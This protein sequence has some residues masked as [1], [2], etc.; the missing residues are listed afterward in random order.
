MEQSD[1]DLVRQVPSYHLQVVMKTRLIAFEPA[2]AGIE[3][4]LTDASSTSLEEIARQIF[5]P[6]SLQT[7]LARLDEL[8]RR[9]LR[10]LVMCGGRANSRDLALYFTSAG[11]LPAK[12]PQS[13]S[14]LAAIPAFTTAVQYPVAHPHGVFEQALYHLLV[15]GL[16]FWGRQTNFTG[17]DYASGV[18]D[19]LLIVP[20]AVQ[21]CVRNLWGE[22]ANALDTPANS[23]G[24]RDERAAR[25]QR[26]LYLYWSLVAEARGGLPLVSNGLLARSALR[27]VLEQLEK[28]VQGEQP[29]QESDMPHLL[30]VRLLLMQLG[31]LQVRKGAVCVAPAEA[32]FAL[33]PLERSRRCYRLYL[34][35]AFWNELLYMPDVYV[36]PVPAPLEPAHE[37]VVR[38][39]SRVIRRLLH[40][41]VGEWCDLAT[42]IARAKLYM[43]DLLFP[44]QYGPRAE[45]YSSGCNPYGRDFRLRRGWLTHRE[46]WHMVEGSFIRAVIGGPLA[47]LGIVELDREET[48]AAFRL[49]P[50]VVALAGETPPVEVEQKPAE[51]LIVQPNFELVVLA[52]VD[53][54]L[55]L[56]LDRFAERISLEHVAQY[57]LTKASVT[58]AIQ[59]GLHAGVILAEL[60]RA[61]G[62]EIPQNV[63]YSVSEWE[64]QA[65]RIELWQEAVL[66]EVDDEALLDELFAQPETRSLFGRRLTSCLAEVL[67]S[68]LA[69]VQRVL[70]QRDYLPTLS[71]ASAGD[72]IGQES[73]AEALEPQ[74]RLHADGLLQPLYA[75]SDLFL[76]AAAGRF[77]VRDEATGWLRITA[78]ALQ[79]ALAARLSLDTIVHFLQR[80]C[81]GGIPGSF[82]LRLRLWGG[83]Y[84]QTPRIS[85]ERA[86]LL[87]L[88]PQVWSDIQADEELQQLLGAEVESQQRLVHVE[89]HNLERVIALLRERGFTIE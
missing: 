57:R 33:S 63:R 9:I 77:S 16:L 39:R 50:A 42:F 47:W 37:E 56:S 74:W 36:R 18:H 41:R 4:A 51:R 10:E 8:E 75:V 45:R 69:E 89:E 76:V 3:S 23:I 73:L 87:N 2:A 11:L 81:A 31:L 68:R 61:A 58:R 17:R 46:G 88:P 1:L 26:L 72:E 19:G 62:R 52:P 55:L 35:T 29:R 21:K 22:E 78:T 12:K 6:A 54:L 43:P 14:D 30:F 60:E 20:L 80:T 27:Q 70:W 7:V 5:D 71:S 34:E 53:E 25:F 13:S 28:K 15:Q 65:R 40:E 48:P 64:R 83:G 44:R 32:F 79:R 67:P 24:G 38:S 84:G 85:V 86:P 82:L 49:S 59:K 66:L